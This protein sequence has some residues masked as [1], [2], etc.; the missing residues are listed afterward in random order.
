[1]QEKAPLTALDLIYGYSNGIFPM[2]DNDEGELYWYAPNPRAI[3]PIDTYRP[4]RS[5]RPVLN[6]R[7]FEVRVNADFECIIRHCAIPRND[8]DGTW[9]SQEVIA[10]YTELHRMGLAHS[11]EAYYQDELAGGLYGVTIG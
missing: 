7:I 8:D 9:I 5:L 10:A 6:Q 11:V 2:A 3:I 1:M 4:A